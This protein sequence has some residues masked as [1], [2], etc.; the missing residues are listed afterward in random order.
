MRVVQ[1]GAC[2]TKWQETGFDDWLE[3]LKA[4]AIQELESF[5]VGL[6]REKGAVRAAL[7]LPWSNGPV[8]GV[9]NRIKLGK[10]MMYGRASVPLLRKMVVLDG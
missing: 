3:R 10:R 8:E 1:H 7:S 5:A 4:S 2:Q 9:V 6:E